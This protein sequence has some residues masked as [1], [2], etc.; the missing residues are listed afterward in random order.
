M[1][2]GRAYFRSKLWRGEAVGLAIPGLALG[3]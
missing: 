2:V 3:A 1:A